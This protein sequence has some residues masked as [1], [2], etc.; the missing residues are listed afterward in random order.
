MAEQVTVSRKYQVV[1][2]KSVRDEV[3]MKPGQKLMVQVR[4]GVVSLVPIVSLDELQ[5]LLR[6]A[7]PEG[8]REEEDRY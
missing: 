8:Y 3:R 5:G 1:I 4:H 7:N 2:P 6:G